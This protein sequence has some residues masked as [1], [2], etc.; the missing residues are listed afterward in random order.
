MME[1]KKKVKNYFDNNE[2][3]IL[4]VVIIIILITLASLYYYSIKISN[5]DICNVKTIDST[6]GSTQDK[7]ITNNTHGT[8]CT[9]SA[10]I[11]ANLAKKLPLTKAIENAKEYITA[12]IKA[13]A[14]YK[15]GRGHGPV[16]HQLL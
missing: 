12:A 2:K 14:N 5:D 7:I 15:I 16:C 9:F 11:A 4:I 8:G 1:D 10:A 6:Q 3:K 13:G